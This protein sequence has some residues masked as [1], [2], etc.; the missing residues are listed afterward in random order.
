MLRHGSMIGELQSSIENTHIIATSAFE[1]V[2]TID[3]SRK[4]DGE[5]WRCKFG[6]SLVCLF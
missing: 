6:I 2:S 4:Y 1:G 3:E 5:G